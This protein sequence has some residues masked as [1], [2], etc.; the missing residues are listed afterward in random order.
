MLESADGPR[1]LAQYSFIGF[2]PTKVVQVKNH[3][4]AEFS[5]D[6]KV[7][8][9]TNDPFTR[10]REVLAE[11]FTTYRGFRF[12]GGLVGYFSY[13]AVRYLETLPN[14]AEDD[15]KFPDMEFGVYDDGIVFDHLTGQAYY[16]WYTTN[17]I[18]EIE[19]LLGQKTKTLDLVADEIGTNVTQSQFEEMVSTAKKYIKDGDI[20]QAVLSKRFH[21]SFKGDLI[22]FYKALRE[23]NPSPYMYFLKMKN[24]AIIGS[25]PEMLGRV[26]GREVDTFPIAGNASHRKDAPRRW[27]V[28]K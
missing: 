17:R 19:R 3:R 12:V 6:K 13:D 25:S 27:K 16:Y 1:K 18:R 2:S 26:D 7:S 11:N 15:L 14:H 4:Y 5:S 9:D 22:G 20:F 28:S 8:I 10:L 23:I 21:C 24:R